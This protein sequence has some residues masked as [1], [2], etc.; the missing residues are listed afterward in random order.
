MAE[1][2]GLRDEASEARRRGVKNRVVVVG[3]GI[4]GVATVAALRSGG[5]VGEIVLVEKAEFPYDRPPLSKEYLAGSRDLKAVALQ[6]PEWYDDQRIDLVGDSVAVAVRP[7]LGEV[8]L[9]DG[10]VV[11]ADKI[12]LATG[13]RA[14]RPQIPGGDSPRVHVLRE[15]EDAD[16]L[17][18]LLVP[19]ARLLVVGAGLI[20]AEA[21]STA[22]ELG[23]EVVLVDPL[24]P[25]IAAAVGRDV[26]AWLQSLHPAHG[27]ETLVTTLES[28]QETPTGVAAQLTG[29]ADSREFDIV[30]LGVGM[31][32]DT[33]LAHAAG[34]VTD[35]G[36]IVDERQVTSHP[37]VLAV[38]DCARLRDHRRTE[39][40]EAAQHDGQRAAATILGLDPPAPTTP[41]FWTDR[42]H[43]HVEGVG[44]MRDPDATT[45]VVVRG[46]VGEPPFSVF[47]LR[48][49]GEGHRVVGAVAVDDSN[50]VRAA[51][52]MIDRGIAVDPQHL[53]DPGTDLRKLLRG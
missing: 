47:T 45:R 17:R 32:P 25:P 19:G 27:V 38:G 46:T 34:L 41:W 48:R 33:E 36:V 30:L 53:A 12:V 23:C 37:D 51:R 39:H 2:R 13:G 28:L 1:N 24:D 5:Y 6:Q 40:W 43:L 8:E 18:Q 20:G 10:R 49:E 15:A 42:Y 16:A 26:A 50:A 52:R 9:A 4:A 14:V 21:A 3:G 31:R 29:E 44:E 22:R 11:T 7:A 35:R